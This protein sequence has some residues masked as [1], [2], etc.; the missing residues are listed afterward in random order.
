MALRLLLVD[1]EPGIRKTTRLAVELAGHSVTEAPNA[2]R[3]LKL[4]DEEAFD[5][6]FLM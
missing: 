1:D 4:A 3:A 5:A 2:Q 6:C